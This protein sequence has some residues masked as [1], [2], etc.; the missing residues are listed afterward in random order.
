[1]SVLSCWKIGKNNQIVYSILVDQSK[2]PCRDVGAREICY[3]TKRPRVV[4]WVEVWK[5]GSVKS[6]SL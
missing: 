5:V 6:G 1:M 2:S 3:K 4:R